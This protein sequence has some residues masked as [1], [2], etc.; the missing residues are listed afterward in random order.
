MAGDMVPIKNPYDYFNEVSYGWNTKFLL[1]IDVTPL[2]LNRVPIFAVFNGL[3][4]IFGSDYWTAFLLLLFMLIGSGAYYMM[5]D[6]GTQV[7]VFSSFVYI[8]NPWVIDRFLSG[9]YLMLLFYALIPFWFRW[10]MDWLKKRDFKSLMGSCLTF[11]FIGFTQPHNIILAFILLGIVLSAF[12]I[13]KRNRR[14]LNSSAIAFFSSTTSFFLLNAFWVIP[15]IL[16]TSSVLPTLSY[17]V[18]QIYTFSRYAWPPLVLTLNG[19]WWIHNIWLTIILLIY[20]TFLL[21]LTIKGA[22]YSWKTNTTKILVAT[23]SAATLLGS[24]V[25]SP[26]GPLCIWAFENISF[27]ALFRDP[28]KFVILSPFAYAYLSSLAFQHS[29]KLPSTLNKTF[30][31]TKQILNKI[32][33]EILLATILCM[34]MGISMLLMSSFAVKYPNEY[35]KLDNWLSSKEGLFNVVFI[36][37]E[38]YV[39]PSWTLSPQADPIRFYFNDKSILSKDTTLYSRDT[40][41]LYDLMNY[42][43]ALNRTDK[44]GEVLNMYNIRFVIVR[45]DIKNKI[46]PLGNAHKYLEA[47]K[48]VKDLTP[49]KNFTD[50]YVFENERWRKPGLFW[51]TNKSGLVVGSPYLLFELGHEDD[52]N[53]SETTFWFTNKLSG[54]A[55]IEKLSNYS[56]FVVFY[57]TSLCDLLPT[58]LPEYAME[59][60][61]YAKSSTNSKAFWIKYSS[62]AFYSLLSVA[63]SFEGSTYGEGWAFTSVGGNSLK[64]SFNVENSGKYDVFIRSLEST[65]HISNNLAFE[66]SVDE[67]SW[68]IASTLHPNKTRWISIPNL[69]LEEG[70]HLLLIKSIGDSSYFLDEVVVAPS[71]EVTERMEEVVDWLDRIKSHLF[72]FDSEDVIAQTGWTWNNSVRAYGGYVLCNNDSSVTSDLSLSFSRIGTYSLWVRGESMGNASISFTIGENTLTRHLKNMSLEWIYMGDVAI[73]KREMDIAIEVEGARHSVGFDAFLFAS[74]PSGESNPIEAVEG[75][76][77][78]IRYEGVVNNLEY[79]VEIVKSGV[80][81]FRQSF[82]PLWRAEDTCAY[83]A[84][85]ALNSFILQEGSVFVKYSTLEWVVRGYIIS[86]ITVIASSFYL[87]LSY[88]RRNL[89]KGARF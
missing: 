84:N 17:P 88:L 18:E 9:H 76:A 58:I 39:E 54:P 75:E 89:R 7:A 36:P 52:L 56:D 37:S 30:N 15:T 29:I 2:H 81:I 65:S 21:Y 40:L 24:G 51:S 41:H 1:G 47:I 14:A 64:L 35:E 60:Y 34:I 83:Q 3:Y 66:V 46:W 19:S 73:D 49:T 11:S 28:N 82:H 4:A 61:D 20:G 6:K 16:Y 23:I 44:I 69:F 43:I 26:I 67:N 78:P 22:I 31:S 68:L 13:I 77:I 48:Q 27:F 79:R 62:E 80:V 72:L 63:P 53:F 33:R 32:N 74:P 59:P 71:S 50:F 38:I 87:I 8:I 55:E 42:F 12:L 85:A 10:T 5:K 70:E 45:L 25:W 57:G 86:I